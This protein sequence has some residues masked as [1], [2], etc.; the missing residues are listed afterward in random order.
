[1]GPNVPPPKRGTSDE[2]SKSKPKKRRLGRR[3]TD[4]QTREVISRQLP[5]VSQTVLTQHIVDG[6]SLFERVREDK[7]KAKKENRKLGPLYWRELKVKYGV[8]DSISD[9]KVSDV[10]EQI[11]EELMRALEQCRNPNAGKRS[12][13]LLTSWC[14]SVRSINQRC[15]VAVVKQCFG[16]KPGTK[17]SQGFLMAFMKCCSR[18]KLHEKYQQD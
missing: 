15:L 5:G 18:L 11:D 6:K 10:S 14:G 13:N 1:M 2:P 8:E 12:K 3:D 7:R 16:M 4:E 17:G 9:L